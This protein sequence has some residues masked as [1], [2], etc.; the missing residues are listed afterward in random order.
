LP[1]QG[2]RLVPRIEPLTVQPLYQIP[3]RELHRKAMATPVYCN[4][5]Q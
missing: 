1:T 2:Q 4:I 5:F 3:S